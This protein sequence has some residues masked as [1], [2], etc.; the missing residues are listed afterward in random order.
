M[1]NDHEI[2]KLVKKQ[3]DEQDNLDSGNLSQ[4]LLNIR[5]QALDKAETE[6]HI[7]QQWQPLKTLGAFSFMA[8]FI[9]GL[10]VYLQSSPEQYEK[11]ELT[12]FEILTTEDNLDF[13]EDLD[14]YQWLLLEE[15]HSS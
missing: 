1:M 6:G 11:L 12:D 10:S 5:S 9:I 13:Y 4:T 3:L 2:I 7:F 15:M 14:F 8:L